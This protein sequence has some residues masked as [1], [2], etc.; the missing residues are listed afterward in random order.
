M[1]LTSSTGFLIIGYCWA[2]YN[3]FTLSTYNQYVHYHKHTWGT[4]DVFNSYVSGAIPFGAIFGSLMIGPVVKL[5]RRIALM[6]IAVVFII[7][8]ATTMIFSFYFLIAGRLIMGMCVGAYATV[9]PLYLSE[10]APPAISATIGVLNQLMSMTGTTIAYAMALMVPYSE[11]PHAKTSGIWRVVFAFPALFALTQLLLL[12]FVHNLETPKFYKEIGDMETYN[13][14]M[15]RIYVDTDVGKKSFIYSI[16]MEP[17]SAN[18][19]QEEHHEEEQTQG[20]I[21]GSPK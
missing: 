3:V 12:I 11:D 5:G 6:I 15:N 7:G 9:S 2:Y 14:I 16:D 18:E 4:R 17:L 13:R 1:A 19:L 10:I 20:L 8:V 21:F